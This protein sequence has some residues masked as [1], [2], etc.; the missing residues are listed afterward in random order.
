MRADLEPLWA[1]LSPAERAQAADDLAQAARR[2]AERDAPTRIS[3]LGSAAPPRA[4][5]G[6]D[7]GRAESHCHG[8]ASG[9]WR[10]GVAPGRL[11]SGAAG[12]PLPS[13][14]A[15]LP[16]GVLRLLAGRLAEQRYGAGDVVLRQ[17]E[18][19][20]AM[21]LVVRGRFAVERLRPDGSAQRLATVEPRATCSANWR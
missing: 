19:G 16:A 6:A 2:G 1:A 9:A 13:M 20:D 21:Y 8:A 12:L 3:R 7:G 18:P 4:A 10:R 5:D 15:G 14:L 11:V 17:G